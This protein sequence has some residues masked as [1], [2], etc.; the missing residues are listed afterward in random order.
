[1]KSRRRL[2]N[3]ENYISVFSVCSVGLFSWQEEIQLVSA[4]IIKLKK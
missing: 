3:D 4:C 2:E 1:M